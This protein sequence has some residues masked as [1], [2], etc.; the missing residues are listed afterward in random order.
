MPT[1]PRS[2]AG[3]AA[4]VLLAATLYSSVGHAGASG[5][6]AAMALY[7]VTPAAMRPTALV[8]NVL[9]ASIG[10]VRFA[11]AGHTPWRL[12]S[13]LLLGSIP[14]AFVGGTMML[15][16]RVFEPVLAALLVLAAVRLWFPGQARVVRARPSALGAVGI[17]AVLGLAA[18]LTGIGGGIFLSPLLI[19]T[20]WENPRAAAGA[21]AP[22]ILANSIAGLLGQVST[23]QAIPHQAGVLVVMAVLGGSVGSWLGAKRLDHLALKRVLAVV[24]LIASTKL[25]AAA[26]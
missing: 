18:G 9:V 21:S 6:L 23:A 19:L 16:E 13:R 22:F 4:L 8:L 15:P 2:L 25:L 1:D 14:A 26:F 7:G 11:S 5:Y 12:L 10:T 17:G 20:G 24:M 3:L